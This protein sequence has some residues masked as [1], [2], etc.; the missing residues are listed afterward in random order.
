MGIHPSGTNEALQFWMAFWPALYS[1]LLYS[2]VTGIVVGVIVL[3]VQRHAEGKAARRSYVRELSIAKE[4]IREAMSCPNPFTISSAIESVPQSARAAIE[5]VR[6]WPISLW[7][8]ELT[9]HKPLLDAIHELQLSYSQ[10]KISAQHFDYLLQ[11]FA[12]DYNSKSNNISVNDPPLQSFIL[13]RFSGFENA[14]ILPWLS[15]PIQTV[16]PWIEGGFAEAEKN[17]ELK[18][19]HGEYIDKREKLQTMANALMQKLTA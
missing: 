3:F 1:G 10:F 8:E 2:I 15:M 16:Y 17:Q 12:R 11:Q 9:D 13:G 18:S 4:Q 14:Q 7:R 19:A 5:V 6:H